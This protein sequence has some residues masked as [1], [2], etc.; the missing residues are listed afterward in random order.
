MKRAELAQLADQL[1]PFLLP[2]IK[3]NASGTGGTAGTTTVGAHALD[4]ATH[5][6]TLSW[7]RVSK[8]GSSLADLQT[9]NYADLTAR[10]HVL[11]TSAGLGPDHTVSGLTTGH[12]LR[13]S[14]ATTAAFAQ[15]AHAELTGVAPDQHH[16]RQHSV[17]STGDHTITGAAFAVLGAT[18]VNTLGLLTPL[19]DTTISTLEALLKSDASGGLRLQ[20]MS[21]PEVRN[22]AGSITLNPT[23][24][25][26]LPTGTIQKDLGDYN[27]KWRTIYGAELYV[28]TLV[29]Q[30]VIST[31]GGRVLVTPTSSLIADIASGTGTSISMDTKHNGFAVGEWLYMAAAPGGVAQ[32][33]VFQVTA[34]PSV[35]TGGYR[36]TVNRN[37]DGSG[38]NAWQAGDAVAS[39]GNALGT[40]YLDLSATTTTQSH[41]G[42][43]ITVY[44]RT[45]TAA[46]TG[47]KPTVSMGNLR[48]FVDYGS[49]EY[50]FALGND[51]TLTPTSGFS[52]MTAD[53]TNGVRMF[54]TDILLYDGATHSVRIDNT[55]GVKLQAFTYATWPFSF[56]TDNTR[57]VTWA[58]SLPSGASIVTTWAN[59]NATGDGY[60]VSVNRS[61]PTAHL[62]WM[63][64]STIY[65]GYAG[66]AR[67]RLWGRDTAINKS[68]AELSS[69]DR[70][71]LAAGEYVSVQTGGLWVSS[72]TARIGGASYAAG[73][74][75]WHEGNFNPASYAALTGAAF[76]GAVSVAGTFT[77]SGAI[78][79]TYGG[80]YNLSMSSGNGIYFASGNV[81][82]IYRTG[83]IL[84][85]YVDAGQAMTLR[86]SGGGSNL[87]VRIGSNT[88]LYGAR[89]Q[90]TGNVH[91]TG[92]VTGESYFQTAA[93][94]VPGAATGWA[95]IALRS[96]DNALVAVMPSG[97]V[98]VLATN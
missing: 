22:P 68:V 83:G 64:A 23:G 9:R 35:I 3:Q 79:S 73:N 71:I 58:A 80:G 86:D 36:Y 26:V 77:A 53:R 40:G 33:E 47:V 13:A 84:Y 75:I 1:A 85:M 31:I 50:G 78:S 18:A 63:E 24:T 62:V 8:V 51:L 7:L 44:S 56:P 48:S 17:T 14:G 89:L 20:Y 66:A 57:G 37:Q 95:R 90:V 98:R 55:Y 92:A 43:T 19:A 5:T 72:G 25:A 65:T 12:V 49:N 30:S 2:L 67:L 32:V 38:Q 74:D 76:S 59:T 45:S 97:A 4:S 42:P 39:L 41:I 69:S 27:R 6:G 54:N 11:A 10:G 52:G 87:Y 60:Y 70:I 88:D 81:G 15:L 46:W 96:S 61:G 29:A 34:G 28:E 93:G 91:A 94:T 21:T 82:N 16:A